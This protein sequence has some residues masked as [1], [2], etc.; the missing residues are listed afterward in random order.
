MEGGERA[1]AELRGRGPMLAVTC[2]IEN[3]LYSK[4]F[5][6][7]WLHYNDSL[8]F[9]KWSYLKSAVAKLGS[10]KLIEE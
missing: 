2:I 8:A 4:Q 5:I 9:T 3:F 1:E 6:C 7:K 10:V